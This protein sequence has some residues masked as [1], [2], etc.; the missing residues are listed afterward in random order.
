[1]THESPDLSF[2]LF[3]FSFSFALYIFIFTAPSTSR[4]AHPHRGEEA[5]RLFYRCSLNTITA[6]LGWFRALRD[7]LQAAAA[8][9][10][11]AADIKE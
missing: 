8:A 3:S 4:R 11:C 10:T 1:M 9:A 7:A 5:L 6:F 2:T